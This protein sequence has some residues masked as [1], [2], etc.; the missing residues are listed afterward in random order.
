MGTKVSKCNQFFDGIWIKLYQKLDFCQVYHLDLMLCVDFQLWD[1]H[2]K[3]A[4][5][6][7]QHGT[8]FGRANTVWSDCTEILLVRPSLCCSCSQLC[9]WAWMVVYGCNLRWIRPNFWLF[10]CVKKRLRE[11]NQCRGCKR[12]FALSPKKKPTACLIT[13]VALCLGRMRELH[14]LPHVDAS[15]QSSE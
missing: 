14:Q 9:M 10:V 5:N 3:F 12:A 6:S 8:M 13:A 1:L 4:L 15:P 11:I 2:T 7:S